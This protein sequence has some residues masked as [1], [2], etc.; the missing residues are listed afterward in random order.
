MKDDKDEEPRRVSELIGHVLDE[1]DRKSRPHVIINRALE[2]QNKIDWRKY[3]ER[4]AALTEREGMAV[5][6]AVAKA[7]ERREVRKAKP[8]PLFQDVLPCPEAYKLRRKLYQ[9]EQ[10]GYS[11]VDLPVYQLGWVN[12]TIHWLKQRCERDAKVSGRRSKRLLKRVHKHGLRVRDIKP[13]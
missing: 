2:R 4:L 11:W 5:E 8:R 13:I 12:M 1:I 9:M 7:Q 6:Q 3:R 10:H